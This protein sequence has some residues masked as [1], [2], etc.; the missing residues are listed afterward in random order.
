VSRDE[1][2]GDACL[3]TWF[4]LLAMVGSP[5]KEGLL[6]SGGTPRRF[7]TRARRASRGAKKANSARRACLVGW[8]SSS[9]Q[10]RRSPSKAEGVRQ[11]AEGRT[12]TSIL[13][14]LPGALGPVVYNRL[15]WSSS[16]LIS[17]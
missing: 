8:T 17:S 3:R 12:R 16:S 7:V 14:G 11:K 1:P 5:K 15:S 4:F 6:L 10:S 13:R 9:V 2:F